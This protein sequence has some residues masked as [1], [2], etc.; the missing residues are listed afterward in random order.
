MQREN[1]VLKEADQKKYTKSFIEADIYQ[2]KFEKLLNKGM[3]F[4]IM[5]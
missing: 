5:I 3:I 1:R 4:R 2:D